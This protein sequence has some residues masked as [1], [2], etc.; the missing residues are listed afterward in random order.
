MAFTDE[1]KAVHVQI[2]VVNCHLVDLHV[3]GIVSNQSGVAMRK[4]VKANPWVIDGNKWL[5][6]FLTSLKTC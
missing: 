3:A 5:L 6:E 1:P 4:A 2:I